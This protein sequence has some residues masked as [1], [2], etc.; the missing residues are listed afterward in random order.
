MP[1]NN[2]FQLGFMGFYPSFISQHTLRFTWPH[3]NSLDL[4]PSTKF[5]LYTFLFYVWMLLMTPFPW[6]KLVVSDL[7]C[8]IFTHHQSIAIISSS[9]L[10]QNWCPHSPL[11]FRVTT[12]KLLKHVRASTSV[13]H[14][15]H[16]LQLY[17]FGPKISS[18]QTMVDMFCLGEYL[19]APLRLL[20]R[21]S[22]FQFYHSAT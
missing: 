7:Y 6:T 22:C 2:M 5:R 4:W 11:M 8:V 1:F 15:N 10:W 9:Y 16:C 3:L 18:T 20:A 14:V 12:K 13:L 17:I 19:L 21:L